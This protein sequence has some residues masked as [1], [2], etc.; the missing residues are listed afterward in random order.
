MNTAQHIRR[1]RRCDVANIREASRATWDSRG[2]IEHINAGSLQRI[3]D[4]T[5]KMASSYDSMRESRDWAVK[6]A[7]EYQSDLKKAH[8]RISALKGVI[9][10]M[11]KAVS[12]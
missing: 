8:N 12:R 3:A 6:R 7:D 11:R 4:A 9:T 2:S 5:E 10:K 1:F